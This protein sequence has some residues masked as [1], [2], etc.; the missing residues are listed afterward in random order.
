MKNI[1]WRSGKCLL[2]A[3]VLLSVSFLHTSRGK[4]FRRDFSRMA[5]LRS[6]MPRNCNIMALTA[7]A[8]LATRKKVIS[9]LEM[10]SC[11]V[12][13]QNPNKVNIFY[14]VQHKPSDL[15]CV[16]RRMIEDIQKNGVNS[17]R[18]I[19]FCRTYD[20]CSEVFR[21]LALE[22]AS[23]NILEFPQQPGVRKF[24]CE[25]FTACSS[26]KT[27]SNIIE[28]FTDPKGTVRIVVA[29]VAFGM[30][31]DT[32]N[33]RHVIHWGP[34]SDIELY[35]QETGRG[36][37]DGAKTTATLF[38][39]SNDISGIAHTSDAMRNYCKNMNDCRRKLFNE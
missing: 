37:R 20:E 27:K 14:E 16:F 19:I 17:D 39:N 29:T 23:R 30:G 26:P 12:L 15:M 33:V 35:V 32:P 38:Y 1:S 28:S 11:Y 36:G 7:T 24:V 10:S 9:N 8:N 3:S 34:P 25:K 31:L 18:A 5:E 6:L 4:E 13:A 22:L 2:P 21:F